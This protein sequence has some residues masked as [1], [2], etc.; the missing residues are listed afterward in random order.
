[1]DEVREPVRA[2]RPKSKTETVQKGNILKFLSN[3]S[4]FKDGEMSGKRKRDEKDVGRM[5]ETPVEK[6]GS[7]S[8]IQTNSV[9]KKMRRGGKI[10]KKGCQCNQIK[11][12]CNCNKIK[13]YFY[14][15]NGFKEASGGP[16]GVKLFDTIFYVR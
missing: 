13:S 9:I 16:K 6:N 10:Q 4:K 1:M 15:F 7:S 5:V 12:N 14:P 8:K 2:R 11:G 3:M